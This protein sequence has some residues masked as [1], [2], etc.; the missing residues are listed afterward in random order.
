M[1]DRRIRTLYAAGGYEICSKYTK[2]RAILQSGFI[3]RA[4]P[5]VPK[6]RNV[7]KAC[8]MPQDIRIIAC[9]SWQSSHYSGPVFTPTVYRYVQLIFS[10]N[11]K[12]QQ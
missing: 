7:C 6:T 3:A 12:G 4:E 9:D 2:S 10:T 11:R 5:D 1:D 8:A